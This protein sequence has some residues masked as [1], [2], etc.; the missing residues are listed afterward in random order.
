ML[1]VPGVGVVASEHLIPGKDVTDLLNEFLEA[2][3]HG[4]RPILWGNQLREVELQRGIYQALLNVDGAK[5]DV[6][7]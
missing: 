7:K 2:R 5:C 4:I 6:G 1:L 3:W